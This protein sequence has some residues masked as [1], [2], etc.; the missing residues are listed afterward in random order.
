MLV[1]V[2]LHA[3]FAARPSTVRQG[4][5]WAYYHHYVDRSVYHRFPYNFLVQHTFATMSPVIMS[6]WLDPPLAVTL[7]ILNVLEA[8]THLHYHST[9]VTMFSPVLKL[10]ELAR[11]LDVNA[12]RKH[13]AHKLDNATDVHD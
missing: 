13:H 9:C 3:N 2:A 6:A 8:H 7:W 4:E 10:L 1:H 5:W 12:H 11:V